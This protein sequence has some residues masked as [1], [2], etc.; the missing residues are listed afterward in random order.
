MRR[1]GGRDRCRSREACRITC[2]R[3]AWSAG[4]HL[5][6]PYTAARR[7]D[8]VPDIMSS[9]RS[10]ALCSWVVAVVLGDAVP[11]AL[12][13]ASP[14]ALD[15]TDCIYAAHD[16]NGQTMGARSASTKELCCTACQETPRCVAGVL[17]QGGQC[18]LKTNLT[19]STG[20]T[21][22][23][24]CLVGKAPPQPAPPPA[25]N[26]PPPS[27]SP[28]GPPC[29]FYLVPCGS[30]V[31]PQGADAP[32]QME[33]D[34][35]TLGLRNLTARSGGREHGFLQPMLYLYSAQYLSWPLISFALESCI[36]DFLIKM[37]DVRREQVLQQLLQE[38]H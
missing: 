25:P 23:T 7:A 16:W 22:C 38:N 1:P 37:L 12:T 30:F 11:V 13:L 31:F 27:P 35:V 8:P 10:R 14:P 3:P 18:Y 2:R 21:G 36:V 34:P 19:S 20:C 4:F 33:I 32:F 29:G 17:D 5:V 28:P 26:P 9:C 15:T 6:E 24:S